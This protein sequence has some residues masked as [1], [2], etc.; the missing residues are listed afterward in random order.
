MQNTPV[1][2]T[3][4]E[5]GIHRMLKRVNYKGLRYVYIFLATYIGEGTE[6]E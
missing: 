6:D 1:S 3:E 4:L 2:V 5:K